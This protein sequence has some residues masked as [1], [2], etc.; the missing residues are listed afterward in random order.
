MAFP[1]GRR[2]VAWRVR[3]QSVMGSKRSFTC[4]KFVYRFRTALDSMVYRSP[5]N[6]PGTLTWKGVAA[7][8]R[9]DEVVVNSV[10]DSQ[11]TD[12]GYRVTPFCLVNGEGYIDRHSATAAYFS[13]RIWKANLGP[14]TLRRLPARSR[15]SHCTYDRAAN[16]LL[17]RSCKAVRRSVLWR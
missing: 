10:P 12:D 11:P 5:V 13:V 8:A 14:A 6:G 15:A 2:M 9:R 3:T 17:S 16:R 1:L 4:P 7:H